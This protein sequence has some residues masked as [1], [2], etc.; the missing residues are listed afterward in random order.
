M[1]E[2]R[3]DGVEQL[4]GDHNEG[5]LGVFALRFLAEIERA[6]LGTAADGVDGGEVEGMARDG[7]ADGRQAWGRGA[8]ATLADHRVEAHVGH[9]RARIGEERAAARTAVASS[10]EKPRVPASWAARRM[11]RG[12]AWA[13]C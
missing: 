2:H 3:V 4:D 6:P 12:L 5:L 8:L 1:L 10:S 9:E 7:R 13:R 11:A